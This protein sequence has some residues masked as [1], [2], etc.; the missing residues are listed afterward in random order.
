MRRDLARRVLEQ[1]AQDDHRALL[2][3]QLGERSEQRVVGRSALPRAGGAGSG[4]SISA[5]QRPRAR[6]V[7]RAVDDDA[8]QPRTER[9]AAVEAVEGAERGEESLLGDV[10]GG[11]GIVND[12]VGGPVGAPP[13]QAEQLVEG[14]RGPALRAAHERPLISPS[15]CHS[16]TTV[17]RI[18]RWRS[19]PEIRVEAG[20]RSMDLSAAGRRSRA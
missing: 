12:E 14:S 19:M 9:A 7:D 6:L 1:V 4:A 20:P 17:R 8:V 15:R 5:P 11:R 16:L 13:V 2:G 18:G 10:L 3:G